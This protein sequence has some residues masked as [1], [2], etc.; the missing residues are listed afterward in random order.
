M[1]ETSV[2]GRFHLT[3]GAVLVMGLFAIFSQ[4][5][6][7]LV[8]KEGYCIWYD[9]C[10]ENH[11]NGKA[12]N[13]LYNG[14]AK[15]MS[16]PE[17]IALLKEVCPHLV[18][19]EGPPLTCCSPSQLHNL[20]SGLQV[21]DQTFSRCPSCLHNFYKLYCEFTCSP[22]QSVF[23]NVTKISTDFAPFNKTHN[24]S[25]SA[26]ETVSGADSAFRPRQADTTP[27][28]E[29]SAHKNGSSYVLSVQEIDY[30]LTDTFA[31]GIYNSC[32]Y[33]LFPSSN[34]RA[35]SMYCGG[36]T[37]DQCSP[38]HF[39][40]FMGDAN[41]GQTP[42][43]INFHITNNKTKPL[44]GNMTSL[45]ASYVACSQAV[46]N[47]TDPCSCQDCPAMCPPQ[48]DVPPPPPE[49]TILGL[50][51]P[52][53]ISI[54][55]FCGFL[56][57]FVMSLA[58]YY[59]CRRK[60]ELRT[61]VNINGDTHPSSNRYV[62]PNDISCIEK[63]GEFFER[64][65]QQLFLMWGRL[66]ANNPI[67]VIVVC[68]VLVAAACVGVM[69]LEITT[70]P[71]EL[72]SAPTSQARLEKNYFD[73]KFGPFY[74]T[75]QLIITSPN[76]NWTTYSTYPYGDVIP[77]GPVLSKDI[78][79][80]VLDLQLQIEHMKV[81]FEAEKRHIT[82]KD[83]CFKPLSPDNDNCTIE[84]VVQYFQN[85]HEQIDREAFD[86]SGL[87]KVAD[88][89]DHFIYCS[90]SPASLNDTTQLHDP[91]LSTYGAPV[92]P[93]VVLGGYD[94]QNYANSTALVITFVVNNYLPG[95]ANSSASRKLDMATT[96]E[97][98]FLEFISNNYTNKNLS[99]SHSAERSVEDEIERESYGDV[100]TILISYLLMFAYVA[101]TLGKITR[102]NR[103]LIDSKITL[104]LSGVLIVLCSVGA[105]LGLLAYC[106]VATT[107]IVIEVMPFLVLAVGVDNIF[108]LVQRYQRDVR[109]AYEDRS[110][111]I[112]RVVGEVGP[113]MLLTSLSE[114]IAFFLGALSSMPA[115]RAFSLYA[116]TAVFI[117]FLLQITAFVA[118]LSLDSK[119]QESGRL[120]VCCCVPTA[121]KEP[122][123]K[124]DGILY[125]FM[126]KYYAPFLM[127]N[128]LRPIVTIIFVFMFCGSAV[129]M[130]KVEVGL[131]QKLSMPEDSYMIDYFNNLSEYLSIGSPV[132]FVTKDGYNFTSE[133]E[134][135]KICGGSGCNDDSLT[136]QVYHASQIS[137]YT[138]IAHPASSWLDDFFD[139]LNAGG[140]IPCCRYYNQSGQ[141]FCPAT[142]GAN[143]TCITCHSGSEKGRRP[144]TKEF[145][146]YLPYFLEDN[147]GTECAKGGHAAYGSAVTF[148]DG[149]VGATYFMT[150]HTTLKT[151]S[152]FIESLKHARN[153]SAN[154]TS[155]LAVDYPGFEVYPY[156]VF[157]VYYEQ[158]L[159]IK[160]DAL[161]N[162]GIS[163]AAIFL[164]TFT[165][166]GLAF[167]SALIICITIIMILVNIMAV[168]YLWN[169]S[170]N[171][172]SL[173]NLVM[174]IGI[175]VEFCSHIVRAFAVNTSLTRKKRA[176]FALGHM[177]SSVLS[178]ITLTKF[179]GIIVLAFA[180]SQ[181][182]KVFYFRMYLC[183]VV[184]G[185][186]HGL[187]FLPV[188]L[189]YAGPSVNKAKLYNEQLQ[190]KPV[191]RSS[192]I[193]E[194]SPLLRHRNEL[195][196]GEYYT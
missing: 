159:S 69:Y 167:Y 15:P 182:F 19:D 168:M 176:E 96:W 123:P 126:T 10:S 63:I 60:N 196:T 145:N 13:C 85:S 5:S 90:M 51:G 67:K 80:Q 6:S 141:P 157:Y 37:A 61:S 98:A 140:A 174:A 119:R 56:V 146:K 23:L 132:Y 195:P 72:W 184:F 21:P 130:T 105:S 24:D 34:S 173:V 82:L 40:D 16:K 26:M 170:L 107:L 32:A 178:G 74:R 73:E 3:T 65:L 95:E 131:D 55:V 50:Y 100:I 124:E 147:P 106:G 39:L 43:Q 2:V 109:M 31:G 158:Y 28:L 154:I 76:H 120:D 87:W 71:V 175:S 160:D 181:I 172:V 189:S 25:S 46:T 57:V 194:K 134:Q 47:D 108:I 139:W 142:V 42:F 8:H 77:F 187:I 38:K 66:C 163:L 192:S 188:F 35:I 92:F 4:A 97:K 148:E 138:R 169:I 135:D 125:S 186:A 36:Y 191:A 185:A 161:F 128:W 183:I 117:D 54:C 81:W 190:D 143:K 112:G 177:G 122:V 136:S 62:T 89:H 45:N 114:S 29:D 118:L 155:M 17:D 150:Y 165:L 113:S 84:S 68:I 101:I 75:E 88:Y 44:P 22:D 152:D 59:G 7:K 116:A 30:Y 12:L 127:K 99:I 64:K 27:V 110:D 153:I 33:V 179:V 180:K 166:L 58:L 115:V 49:W 41:N 78:L 48:P 53:F 144:T 52:L 20:K 70:N 137:N 133:V 129:L 102:C 151:S 162:L 103:L 193:N 91:C 156:S 14:P 111:Q 104:G 11:V 149:R 121:K 18:P 164:V 1:V 171:A 83:I 9:V 79:H 93:W 86:S 94:G